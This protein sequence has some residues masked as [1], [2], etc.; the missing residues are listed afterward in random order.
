MTCRVAR[1]NAT[2]RSYDKLT[3]LGNLV[4]RD[5]IETADDEL[6][7]GL[8]RWAIDRD[9]RYERNGLQ[10]IFICDAPFFRL[11]SIRM[12]FSENSR[13]Q[14]NRRFGPI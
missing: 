12:G 10:H 5:R 1:P 8:H 3:K 2:K 14:D 4:H 9:H 6:R 7:A 11:R 13:R